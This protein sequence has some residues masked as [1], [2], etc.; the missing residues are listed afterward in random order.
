MINDQKNIKKNNS[1]C[2]S[3]GDTGHRED[4]IDMV[5]KYVDSKRNTNY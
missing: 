2:R 5:R 1:A 4:N 3:K